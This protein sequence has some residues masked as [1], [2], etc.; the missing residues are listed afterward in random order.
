MQVSSVVAYWVCAQWSRD[1]ILAKSD[2]YCFMQPS[3]CFIL[4]KE[5]LHL[6]CLVLKDLLPYVILCS[7]VIW[8]EGLFHLT[9]SYV[10]HVGAVDPRYS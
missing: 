3:C 9:S 7:Y 5:L 10:C 6:N 2:F 1:Q 4:H 8:H